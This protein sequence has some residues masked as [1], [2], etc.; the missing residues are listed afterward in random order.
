[1]TSSRRARE[2]RRLGLALAGGGPGG[3]VYEIG[4]LRALEDSLEG[5]DLNAVDSYVGVSAGSVIAA[6]LANGMSSRQL[7]RG[8]VAHEPGEHP[9]VP[10]TFYR[11]AYGEWVKR[12][13]MVPVAIAESV[14]DVIA[15]PGDLRLADSLTR[16]AR[17]L[18]VG[19]FDNE[20][21]R[22]YFAHV[23]SLHGR[24]DDFR[25]LP[26]HLT[27]VAADLES[28]RPVRF[29]SGAIDDVPIS[30]AI[31]ASTAVPG[32]Y[33]P[34]NI[35]GRHCVD[36]VL[37]KTVHASVALDDHVDLLLCVNPIVPAD[38]RA[39]VRRGEMR[40]GAI[41]YGGL[42][43]VLSQTFRT[44]VH[45]RMEVGMGAYANRYPDADV[46][47]FEPAR[48]EYE[49]FFN[50][51]FSFSSRRAVCEL[52]FRA[53]REDLV[54]RREL[55]EPML[56][57]H[58]IGYRDAHLGDESREVWESVGLSEPHDAATVIDRLERATAGLEGAG[59]PG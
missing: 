54:R 6:C 34:V 30:R 51:I 22:R 42:A 39:G 53:T 56:E 59:L 57:R 20:P 43:T 19:V 50:N 10:S 16:L 12:G 17:C 46:V 9:F 40:P 29:G 27:V 45:S 11:P 7:V 38:T 24:T 13:L 14:R 31:Q 47:L 2:R 5:L 4:A 25:K 33:P 37:L 58:G 36:G 15:R 26:R 3:A 1:M 44:L 55:L 52:G 35:D 32:V 41:V 49:M 28:G 21:I 18:P 23:F 8:I 48:D